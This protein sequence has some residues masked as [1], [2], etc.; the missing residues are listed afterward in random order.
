VSAAVLSATFFHHESVLLVR[1]CRPRSRRS[2]VD[3]FTSEVIEHDETNKIFTN[4]SQDVELAGMVVDVEMPGAARRRARLK[5]RQVPPLG[6]GCTG[7]CQRPAKDQTRSSE[8][9]ATG[10]LR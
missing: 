6:R 3:A 7:S 10:G 9:L 8:R 1:I 5:P 4:P 2:G